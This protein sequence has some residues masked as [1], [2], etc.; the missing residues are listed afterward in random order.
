MKSIIGVV[1]ILFFAFCIVIAGDMASQRDPVFSLAEKEIRSAVMTL[2]PNLTLLY[3]Y[4]KSYNALMVKYKARKFM[5]HGASKIG[6]YS[7]KAHEKEGPSYQGFILRLHLQKAGTVNQAKVPQTIKGPYWRSDL[8][9]TLIDKSD[10]Q[11]YWALSYGSRPDKK[12]LTAVKKAVNSLGHP[13][14]WDEQRR[15]KSTR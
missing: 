7:E 5:V 8:N 9:I 15:F 3:E 4:P 11:F 10:K 13:Y 14:V 1:V 6:K 12:L 2:D